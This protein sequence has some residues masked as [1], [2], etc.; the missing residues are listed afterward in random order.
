M[1]RVLTDIV[2]PEVRRNARRARRAARAFAASAAPLAVTEPAGPTSLT[3]FYDGGAASVLRRVAALRRTV[4]AARP[5]I[6]FRDLHRFP[7]A[8]TCWQ[9]GPEDWA[10]R[11]FVVDRTAVLRRGAGALRLL[12]RETG[13]AVPHGFVEGAAR[14][15][16]VILR[17]VHPHR[18]LH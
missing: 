15:L 17:A 11:L 13:T 8:L 9:V 5:D 6:L 18:S 1:A 7:H 16:A 2:R 4:G 10:G 14:T 12:R 3:V